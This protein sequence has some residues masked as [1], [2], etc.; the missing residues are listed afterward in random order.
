MIEIKKE[1]SEMYEHTRVYERCYFCHQSTD[2]WHDPSNT[3]VCED[4]S[5][6]H[7][8]EEIKKSNWHT[9]QSQ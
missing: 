6:K 3:P 1:P 9:K 7:T 4:C 2:T 8:V 5:K